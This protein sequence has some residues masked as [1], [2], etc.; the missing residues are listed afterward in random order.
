MSRAE[1]QSSFIKRFVMIC[2]KSNL[3]PDLTANFTIN[4]SRLKRDGLENSEC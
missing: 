4:S 1:M 3:D 2:K